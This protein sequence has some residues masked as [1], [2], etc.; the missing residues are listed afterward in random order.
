MNQRT[1]AG[2]GT[3]DTDVS[4]QEAE[5]A[6]CP[7]WSP[8]TLRRGYRAPRSPSKIYAMPLRTGHGAGGTE[9]QGGKTLTIGPGLLTWVEMKSGLIKWERQNLKTFRRKYMKS[10]RSC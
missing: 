2:E 1:A 7:G 4:C 3:Q 10:F 5:E 9:D 8:S 6:M